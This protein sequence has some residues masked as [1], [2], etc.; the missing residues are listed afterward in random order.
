MLRHPGLQPPGDRTRELT[1]PPMPMSTETP[2]LPASRFRGLS[3][4][5][6]TPFDPQGAIDEQA[7]R[8]HVDRLV[9]GGVSV[10]MPCGTTG[11]GV[12]LSPEEH[13]RVVGIVVD[14]AG[15]RVPVVAGAGSSST[16]AAADLAR[17]SV[18]AGADGLLC[19]TPAYNRP[20]RTGLRDHF[21]HLADAAGGRPIVLYNVP[22]RTAVELDADT[23]LELAGDPRFVGVKEASGGLDLVNTV[24]ASRPEGFLVLA[25]DD[26][27]AL[28]VLALG[29]DGVVSVAA[30]EAPAPMAALVDAGLHGRLDEARTLHR[31][32]LPIMRAN[33]VESNPGPVKEACHILGWMEPVLRP[34]LARLEPASA[35]RLRAAMEA[36]GLLSGDDG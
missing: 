33:F 15:G 17:R 21:L 12:T 11:E 24:L 4:A 28:P 1:P 2:P 23:I 18:S 31:R 19:V 29:G 22:G 32:L 35:A 10:L 25:G 8:A 9:E 26:E 27:L 16:R 30:N 20:S 3:V 13:G 5:M 6:V 34:P 14:A 36:S 7:L